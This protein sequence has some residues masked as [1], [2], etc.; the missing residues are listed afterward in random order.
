MKTI[1]I[2][3]AIL[4]NMVNHANEGYPYEVCGIIAGK[5]FASSHIYRMTNTDRS[6]VSYRMDPKEQLLIEKEIK[7]GN[8][9]MLAI[10]HSHPDSDAFP[11]A[12][13]AQEAYQWN[14]NA[15]YIIIGMVKESPFIRAF[16]IENGR[17]EEITVKPL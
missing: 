13:D 1:E 16:S 7:R 4:K 8:E 2:P 12:K 17:I 14:W 9:K 15:L 11:S 6:P 10:Y 3:N 5:D